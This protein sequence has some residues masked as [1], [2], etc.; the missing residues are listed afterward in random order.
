M[1][2]KSNRHFIQ[3][4]DAQQTLTLCDKLES[5]IY[6]TDEPVQQMQSL[7]GAAGD[8]YCSK[9]MKQKLH[10]KIKKHIFFAVVSGRKNAVCVRNSAQHLINDKWYADRQDDVTK[11]SQ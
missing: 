10:D 1:K 7:C 2:F 9:Y 4:R 8:V 3:K 6:T 11:K 5:E